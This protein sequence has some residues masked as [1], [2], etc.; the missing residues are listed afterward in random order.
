MNKNIC[1]DVETLEYDHSPNWDLQ[2]HK[3]IDGNGFIKIIIGRPCKL[4]NKR[5]WKKNI[6]LA[7]KLGFDV[8]NELSLKEEIHILSRHTGI[9]PERVMCCLVVDE[10]YVHR[11]AYS[12]KKDLGDDVI[13][14]IK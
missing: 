1:Y 5:Q 6:K 8:E 14:T 11:A 7:K 10:E 2:I 13:Y 3:A 12:T 9:I 4:K